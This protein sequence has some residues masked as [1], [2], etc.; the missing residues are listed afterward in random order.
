[1][2]TGSRETMVRQISV[3]NLKVQF[4]SV[5]AISNFFNHLLAPFHRVRQLIRFGSAPL[6]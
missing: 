2:D 6:E 1:M 3:N 4:Y 5:L